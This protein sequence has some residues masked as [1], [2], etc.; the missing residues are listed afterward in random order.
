MAT[1]QRL[2][3]DFRDQLE[4]EELSALSDLATAT[5]Q[6][7]STW[8]LSI[9]KAQGGV[10]LPK[11]RVRWANTLCNRPANPAIEFAKITKS[12]GLFLH[13]GSYPAVAAMVAT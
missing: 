4:I 13:A 2:R 5:N 9:S 11:V 6:E 8:F 10:K 7:K 3:G 12:K 1:A